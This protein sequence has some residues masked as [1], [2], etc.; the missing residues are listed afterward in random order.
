MN[1]AGYGGNPMNKKTEANIYKQELSDTASNADA[2]KQSAS[3]TGGNTDKGAM[4]D[5]GDANHR[6]SPEQK[7]DI[8]SN[9]PRGIKRMVAEDFAD[10]RKDKVKEDLKT[11]NSLELQAMSR[12][13]RRAY[14]KADK[15]KLTEGMTKR[16]RVRYFVD[17][18]KWGFLVTLMVIVSLSW[19]SFAIYK[20]T[21]PVAV[22][23]GIVNSTDPYST[24]SSIFSDYK[25]FYGIAADE[26]IE[27]V[28]D[29]S[30]DLDTF[31]QDYNENAAEYSSFPMLCDENHYDV[32]FSNKKGVECCS[33][34]NLIF[35][36]DVMNDELQNLI[37][38]KLADRVL[39]TADSAGK[40]GDFAVD[41]SGTDFAESLNLGYDDVY[42]CFPGDSEENQDTAL[43][44]LNYIFGLN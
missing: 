33:Y 20:Q 25:S 18:Y 14:R 28:S 27:V 38:G 1:T 9:Q 34:I 40:N 43:K 23:Y 32:L 3:D 2:D 19:I 42:M 39:V 44:L 13:E 10:P 7:A 36:V 17:C 37:Y 4:S 21:R 16:Q 26:K 12:S 24:D 29:L 11:E 6:L 15:A 5:A 31:E 30:Y 8:L 41:I 35:T 22:A